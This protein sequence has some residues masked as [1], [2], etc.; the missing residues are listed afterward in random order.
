MST[1]R[2]APAETGGAA[3]GGGASGSRI[4]ALKPFPSACL[5]IG[6]QLLGE[7]EITLRSLAMYVIE[8]NRLT[9]TRSLG[10]P[11]V[12]RDY[13]PKDLA[14]KEAA[15]VGADLPRECGPLV[16]HGQQDTLDCQI[17]VEGL[18]NAHQGVKQLRYPLQGEVLTLDGD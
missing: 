13:G 5:G 3:G 2:G 14:T 18:S 11:D 15:Q 6:D 16:K 7:L 12:A 10:K 4:S 1:S 8:N 17:G 9:M